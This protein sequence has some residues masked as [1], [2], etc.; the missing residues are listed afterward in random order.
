MFSP[1]GERPARLRA[2]LEDQAAALRQPEV[3]P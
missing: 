1:T 3:N 2:F